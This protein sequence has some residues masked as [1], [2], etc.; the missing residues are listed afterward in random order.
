MIFP[1]LRESWLFVGRKPV[2]WESRTEPS[3]KEAAAAFRKQ[4]FKYE[5]NGIKWDK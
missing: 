4:Y 1:S 3:D 2:G 5:K